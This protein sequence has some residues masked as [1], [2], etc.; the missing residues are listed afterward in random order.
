[1]RMAGWLKGE[2]FLGLG[3][4]LVR[5]LGFLRG[6]GDGDGEVRVWREAAPVSGHERR[7]RSGMERILMLGSSMAMEKLGGNF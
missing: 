7:R 1:M 6:G 5:V 3:F 2:K 4:E